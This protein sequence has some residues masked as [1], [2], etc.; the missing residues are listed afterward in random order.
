MLTSFLVLELF[1]L[2]FNKIYE[3][4]CGG[5][6]HSTK[7]SGVLKSQTILYHA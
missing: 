1:P 5:Y 2:L 3:D 7:L 4:F 6:C